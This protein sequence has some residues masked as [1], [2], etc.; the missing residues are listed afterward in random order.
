MDV[1]SV[2]TR[3][4]QVVMR[5]IFRTD[6]STQIGT[7]HV[8]RCLTLADAL[9]S[10]GADCQFIC[11]KHDGNLIDL[12]QKK[13]YLTHA[14]PADRAQP[15]SSGALLDVGDPSPD[16]RHWLGTTQPEDVAACKPILMTYKPDWLVVDHYGLDANWENPLR[17]Y[18]KKLMVIDD[19][20]DRT[21]HA[22]ILLDQTFGRPVE[23]YH[24]WV[25]SSCHVL[26]GSQYALL[27]PEFHHLRPSSLARRKS[28]TLRHLLITLGGVDKDN[29][30]SSVLQALRCTPL[31][32]DCRITVVL[33]HNAPK[34]EQVKCEARDMPW[35]TRTVVGVNHMALLMVESDLAIGAAGTTTWERCCLGLPTITLVLAANQESV[36]KNLERAG[37]TLIVQR[38][39]DLTERLN[40]L[41]TSLVSQPAQLLTL[42]ERSRH[43]VD[44]SGISST[45]RAMEV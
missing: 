34:V 12:I 39:D 18:Y 37:A 22:D 26:C 36:A 10:R 42:S 25:P 3:P 35:K 31:P 32:A 9:S 38:S 6:A 33:G 19:L 24:P 5:V 23:D 1:K 17:P 7:G 30:T 8:M 44:G 21:H 11:R 27:R 41:I 29:V 43:I 13:G 15:G 28:P 40:C 45:V 14:L 20:A 2:L 4:N 16:H